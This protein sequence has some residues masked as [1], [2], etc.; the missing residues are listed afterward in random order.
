MRFVETPLRGAVIL[1]IEKSDDERGFFARTY[2]ERE[3]KE[4]GLTFEFRQCSV[5]YNVKKG[6]IRGLHYQAAP[7]EEEKIVRCTM[8]AIFDVAVD[9]RPE[10]PSFRKWLGVELNAENRRMLFLPKGLAHGFQTLRDG[11]EV[12]YQISGEYH[13][14]SVRG[15]RWDDPAFR[16][17]WPERVTSISTRDRSFL[18]F[19]K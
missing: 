7:H 4:H 13:P 2:C 12:F 9:L 15:V 11:S 17:D 6:T 1:E 3:F 19:P 10:S 5:S 18:D 14:E 16:V 8:G